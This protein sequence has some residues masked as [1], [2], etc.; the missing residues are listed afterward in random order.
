MHTL[1]IMV[2]SKAQLNQ[3]HII[4]RSNDFRAATR[5]Q[6]PFNTGRAR[7]RLVAAT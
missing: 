3:Q 4:E 5:S 7:F 1:E 2:M 6:Y